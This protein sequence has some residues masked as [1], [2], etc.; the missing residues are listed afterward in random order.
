MAKKKVY[1]KAKANTST[2][3]IIYRT[4]VISIFGCVVSIPI[5]NGGESIRC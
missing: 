1:Y 3:S 2:I 5:S 4:G